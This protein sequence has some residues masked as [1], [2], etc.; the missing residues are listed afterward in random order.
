MQSLKKQLIRLAIGVGMLFLGA[1]IS[2]IGLLIALIVDADWLTLCIIGLLMAII[3]I[4]L[5]VREIRSLG[6]T[7]NSSLAE[8]LK[9][10]LSRK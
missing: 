1:I 7:F 4:I 8:L 9:G 5:I 3:G 10:K 2:V 6:G